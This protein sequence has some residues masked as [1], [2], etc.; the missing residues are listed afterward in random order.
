MIHFTKD[1]WIAHD[2]TTL[3]VVRLA[4][5]SEEDLKVWNE[6]TSK[7]KYEPCPICHT[8]TTKT[9]QKNKQYKI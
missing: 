1:R 3:D 2:I 4:T 9:Q 6:A 5:L 8:N 7:A